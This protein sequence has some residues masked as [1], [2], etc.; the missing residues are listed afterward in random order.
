M[1]NPKLEPPIHSPRW[2]P[3]VLALALALFGEPAWSGDCT[4]P[5]APPR[6]G[7][8]LLLQHGDDVPRAVVEAA[9]GYWRACPGYGIDFPALLLNGEGLRRIRIRGAEPSDVSSECGTFRGDTVLL[10]EEAFDRRGRLVSCGSLPQ[11]LAHEL[12]HVLGLGHL[13]DRARCRTHIMGVVTPAAANGRSVSR[14]ECAAAGARWLTAGEIERARELDH[15]DE[16]GFSAPLDQ[17]DR[18]V[19]GGDLAVTHQ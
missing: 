18:L 16:R 12:G 6:V 10:H 15:A 9:I 13:E 11:N 7:D 5:S 3:G 14:E 19:N 4:P 2:L 8:A 1:A 17:L